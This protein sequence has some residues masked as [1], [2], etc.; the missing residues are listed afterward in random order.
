[1]SVASTSTE[2]E[3]WEQIIRPGAGISK[4][5]A[6]RILDLEFSD[7]GRVRSFRPGGHALVHSETAGP[8]RAK[9]SSS[10]LLNADGPHAVRTS[11]AVS[12]R[13]SRWD[14]SQQSTGWV[15]G[16]GPRMT[17]SYSLEEVVSKQLTRILGEPK[18][19]LL[20]AAQL[21]RDSY[22]FFDGSFTCRDS[23]NFVGF[24]PWERC[25]YLISECPR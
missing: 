13:L 16:K 15:C 8:P 18:N 5:A 17:P 2:A 11:L 4:E 22:T 1:V 20:I 10:Q 9:V 7:R 24:K 6:R 12:T 23:I 3:I 21:V 14:V 19:H 25:L